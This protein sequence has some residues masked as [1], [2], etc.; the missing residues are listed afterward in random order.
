MKI[1]MMINKA[2]TF[3]RWGKVFSPKTFMF[4]NDNNMLHKLTVK[5]MDQ[6][7]SNSAFLLDTKRIQATDGTVE[8]KPA[9]IQAKPT[10]LDINC[11]GKV[12]P[13]IASFMAATAAKGD[14]D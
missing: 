6:N 11:A 3:R 7:K 5:R 2:S 8:G 14:P 13:T 9:F 4:S 1:V 10:R 12:E